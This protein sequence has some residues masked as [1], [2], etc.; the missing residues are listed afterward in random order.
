MGSLRVIVL[1]DTKLWDP[2]MQGTPLKD[3]WAG[4]GM[5]SVGEWSDVPPGIRS[6]LVLPSMPLG[7]LPHMTCSNYQLCAKPPD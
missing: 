4:V 1:C 7:A 5:A 6:L 3:G 2:N